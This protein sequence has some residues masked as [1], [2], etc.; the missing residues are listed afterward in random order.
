MI[1]LTTVWVDRLGARNLN[2]QLSGCFTELKSW[3]L[4]CPGRTKVV[5]TLGLL[6]LEVIFS[7]ISQVRGSKRNTLFVQL[8]AERLVN[9]VDCRLGGAIVSWDRQLRCI[10]GA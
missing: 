3:V 1:F 6:Y 9:S 5:R 10:Q 2:S 4:M 8:V 7:Q